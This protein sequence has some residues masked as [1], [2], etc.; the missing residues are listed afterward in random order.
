MVVGSRVTV[1]KMSRGTFQVSLLSINSLAQKVYNW[2][3]DNDPDGM[4]QIIL[5]N[6]RH[7]E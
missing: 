7:P 4:I 1:A 6:L 5:F 2:Q 3:H